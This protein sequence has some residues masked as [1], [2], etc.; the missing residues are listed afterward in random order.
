MKKN[1]TIA[2][3]LAATLLVGGTFAGTKAL[4]SDKAE[5]YNDLVITMGNLNVDVVEGEWELENSDSESENST[6]ND[7]FTNV[8]PG[9]SFLKKVT[10]T[11]NG[12]LNQKL[13]VEQNA[14]G[15]IPDTIKVG[16]TLT[17]DLHGKTL[18]PGQSIETAINVNIH[19]D[20][21]GAYGE[22]GSYNQN[23]KPTFNFNELSSVFEITAEQIHEKEA[24]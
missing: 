14:I 13:S 15:A 5:A 4:F 8:K 12:S 10:V 3:A 6:N 16:E 7:R 9:D 18:A 21:G 24:K 19:P 22:E 2:Y 11:N 20:M 1:K 17:R 23:Q